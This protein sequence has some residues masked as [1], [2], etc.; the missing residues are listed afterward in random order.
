MSYF[1]LENMKT[2]YDKGCLRN[3]PLRLLLAL[4]NDT[5]RS[6]IGIVVEKLFEFTIGYNTGN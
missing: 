6:E 4:S 5:L 2:I 1:Y 3:H